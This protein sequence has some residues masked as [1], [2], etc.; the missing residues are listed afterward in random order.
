MGGW[1]GGEGVGGGGG[2]RGM[3]RDLVGVVG[4]VKGGSGL[5]GLSFG[6]ISLW[7]DVV[8]VSLVEEVR[9]GRGGVGVCGC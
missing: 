7:V 5:K 4:E 2:G 1:P 3:G 9:G 6:G 8:E